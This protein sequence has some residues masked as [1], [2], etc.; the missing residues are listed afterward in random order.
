MN[1]RVT[2]AAD[3]YSYGGCLSYRGTTRCSAKLLPTASS[4]GV[5]LWEICTGEIPIRGQLRPLQVPEEAPQDI[6]ALID[7]CLQVSA[8]HRPTIR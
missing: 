3:I 1:Q 8:K 5:L 4:A 6:A 7:D 2:V